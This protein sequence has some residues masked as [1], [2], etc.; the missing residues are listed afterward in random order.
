VII[1]L[2]AADMSIEEVLG[3][4][5]DL[6]REDIL[7]PLEYAAIVTRVGTVLPTTVS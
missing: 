2:L 5:P 7:A 1:A 3:D 6:E 4:H